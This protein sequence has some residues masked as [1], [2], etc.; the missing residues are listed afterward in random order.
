MTQGRLYKI[1]FLL[2]LLVP[3]CFLWQGCNVTRNV[4]KGQYLLR[5]NSI[6]LKASRNVKRRDE[7]KD[8]LSR[9]VIQQPN[10]YPFYT[11]GLIPVKLI[12]YNLNPRKYERDTVNFQLKSHTVERPVIFDTSAMRR[13][14][15]NMKSFMVNQGYFYAQVRDTARLTKRKKAFVTYNITPGVNYLIHHTDFASGMDDSTIK[16]LL[17]ETKGDSYLKSGTEFSYSL[18]ESERSRITSVLRDHGYFKFSQENISFVLDTANKAFFADADNLFDNAVRFIQQQKINKKPTCDIQ[19]VI[20]QEDE[21]DAYKRY[22]IS[23]VEVY[24]DFVDRK[25]F[26]DS[27]MVEKTAQGLEFKYHT[28]YVHEG[29]LARHTYIL[30]GG[31]YTQSDYDKTITKLNELGIFQYIRVVFREDTAHGN[32]LICRIEMNRNPKH[33]L[34]TNYEVSNGSTYIAGTAITET[35]RDINFCKGANLLSITAN[36]GVELNDTTNRGLLQHL[37]ILTKYYGL[38]ASIDFPKF[39]APFAA[40]RFTNTNL[41]HTII[42]VGTNLLDRVGYFSL[43]NTN[44]SF[45]YHWRETPT[46]T[47]D[48][49]PA[50]INIIRLPNESDSF[51]KRLEGNQFLRDSYKE[52]FIEGENLTFTFSNQDKNAGRNYTYLR[53]GVEEA[54]ALLSGIKNIGFALNDL[55]KI[56]FAQYAKFD[57]DYRHYFSLRRSVFAIRFDGG[58]GLPYGQSDALPYIKQYYVGGPYS[59]RGWRIRSLGPGSSVDTGSSTNNFIDRTGDIKLEFNGEYRFGI[60][61]LFAGFIK[62]NGAFFADAGNIWLS[63][64]DSNYP[65]GEFELN[66]FARDI[67]ADLGAGARFDIASFITLRIDLAFPVKKPYE[68]TNGGWVFDQIAFGDRSWRSNNLIL[69]IAVGYPF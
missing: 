53:L 41:P 33:V 43:V 8:N 57:F 54:G 20:R 27:A 21:P 18:F 26:R 65:G 1:R 45:T 66:T 12:L 40:P 49:S 22:T 56:K 69:N 61:Q 42:S 35:F 5:G 39:L 62:L 6:K 48:F 23:K 44:A 24:P 38:N 59:L 36:A 3:A 28:Y 7:M 13:S 32:K 10:T 58:I 14:A 52:N 63:K 25:D 2:F 19:V 60:A 50:F 31:Y 47:W 55:Y 17:D 68:T 67:A 51:K 46:K 16:Q 34:A 9:L 37:F 11:L 64:K 30:P 15:Q 29:V 4:P